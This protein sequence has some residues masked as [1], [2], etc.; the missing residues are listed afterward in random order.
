MV[1]LR[2]MLD[3]P[4]GGFDRLYCIERRIAVLVR[5]VYITAWKVSIGCNLGATRRADPSRLD[6]R[7]AR[8]GRM[9][10]RRA[11]RGRMRYTTTQ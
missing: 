7:G 5:Y 6:I 10:P 8:D 11:F 1:V 2:P 4:S 9:T 3:E